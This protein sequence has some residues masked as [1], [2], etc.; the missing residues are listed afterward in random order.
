[1]N[2]NVFNYASGYFPFLNNKDYLENIEKSVKN[3]SYII[4]KAIQQIDETSFNEYEQFGWHTMDI[5][6]KDLLN[7]QIIF[8]STDVRIRYNLLHV[9]NRI[10]SQRSWTLQVDAF[11]EYSVND[12]GKIQ[13]N[14]LA[15]LDELSAWFHLSRII[16][17]LHT[18]LLGNLVAWPLPD[19]TYSNVQE[20]LTDTVKYYGSNAIYAMIDEEQLSDDLISEINRMNKESSCPE[21]YNPGFVDYEVIDGEVYY[22]REDGTAVQIQS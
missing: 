21:Y 14:K 19:I 2:F 5:Y 9:G 22:L 6:H 1:M 16:S 17:L 15:T 3:D 8:K 4:S 7:K 18:H 20:I 12:E 11:I 10:I 13:I